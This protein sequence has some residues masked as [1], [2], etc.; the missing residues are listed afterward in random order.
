MKTIAAVIIDTYPDKVMPQ[1]AVRR[2][3]GLSNV[4]RLYTLSD[5]PFVP[6]ATHHEIQPIHSVSEYSQVV[7]RV[8]PDIVQEEHF[9][10]IQ[11]DGMPVS[12]A[13]WEESFLDFDYIGAPWSGLPEHIAV[14]NGGFSLRSRRLLDAVRAIEIAIDAN[15]D[16]NQA[17]DVILCRQRRA[18]LEALGIKF[19]PSSV[20][21]R[22]SYET[23]PPPPVSF[24]FH[25]TFNFPVYFRE[26][27]LLEL[28][29]QIVGRQTNMQI[30]LIYLH[31]L[32]YFKM[33]DLLR[34]SVRL[35]QSKPSLAAAV[36]AQMRTF[37][38]HEMVAKALA[39]GTI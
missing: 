26:D 36:A 4:A 22:F 37:P 14:G 16:P 17:E 21:A 39:D 23:G 25:N 32:V 34:L 1:F 38:I 20:A 31:R 2:T 30:F 18:H 19:A 15:G 9:L 11:W 13:A 27:E 29:E 10:L 5:Q 28:A 8:L 33:Y 24:G 7:L 3:V 12:P 35:I 6:G